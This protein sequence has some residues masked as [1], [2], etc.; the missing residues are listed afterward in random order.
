[1]VREKL[2]EAMSETYLNITLDFVDAEAFGCEGQIGVDVVVVLHEVVIVDVG[3]L[4]EEE[5]DFYV[6]WDGSTW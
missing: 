4:L 3:T 1:M 2:V 6:C 5:L